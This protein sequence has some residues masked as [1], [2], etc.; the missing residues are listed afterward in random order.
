MTVAEHEKT[1]PALPIR[2]RGG[3]PQAAQATADAVIRAVRETPGPGR[4]LR[5]AV[6]DIETGQ[7]L[8]TCFVNVAADGPQLRLVAS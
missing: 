3:H 2:P 8:G 5:V 4:L 1:K 6:T 7:R